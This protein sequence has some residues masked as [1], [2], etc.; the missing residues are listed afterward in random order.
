MGYEK[1]S[2]L[3]FL[4]VVT[5]FAPVSVFHSYFF[6]LHW[7]VELL[8]EQGFCKFVLDVIQHKG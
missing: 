1:P 2:L 5:A 4:V 6:C 3:L 8:G 7:C